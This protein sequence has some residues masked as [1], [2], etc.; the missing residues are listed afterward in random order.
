MRRVRIRSDHQLSRQGI[1]FEHNR[2]ADA[3]RTFAIG[4]LSVKA[5]AF[6]FGEFAL[7][8]L[9]LS[10]EIEQAHPALLLGQNF[11]EKRG[12]ISKEQH[13]PWIVDGRVLADELI[14]E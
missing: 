9:E 6:A 13:R 5:D 7:L 11:V 14:E 10:C 3:L 12:V 4:E 2:V 1:A 8:Q